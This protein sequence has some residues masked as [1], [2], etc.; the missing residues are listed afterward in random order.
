MPPALRSILESKDLYIM[1]W[2]ENIKVSAHD[3]D[4]NQVVSASSLIRYMQDA[5]N[6]QLHDLGP[7]NE[8]LRANGRA[9]IL[10]RIVC[11]FYEPAY[12]YDELTV[13]TWSRDARGYSMSRFHRIF[14][15]S[16]LIAVAE[17]TWALVDIQTKHP[18]RASE[19]KPNFEPDEKLELDFPARIH[20]PAADS[21]SKIFE[22][23]VLYSDT[24]INQ[25]MNNT[26]YPDLFCNAINM[27]GK[28]PSGISI[29]FLSEAPIGEKLDVYFAEA[30]GY[31]FFR[32]IREDGK[33]NTEAFMTLSDI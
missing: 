8:E 30:D 5:A 22:Y 24:D 3:T 13:Q 15:G 11:D 4:I 7:S 1:K 14:R 33:I 27:R 17:T 31:L 20:L 10:S 21:F 23:T 25:H 18:L 2:T 28:R 16:T 32:S 9:F 12:N 29:S 26:K 6:S 19:F